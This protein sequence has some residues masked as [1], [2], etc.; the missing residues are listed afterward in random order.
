[1]RSNRKSTAGAR[2]QLACLVFS[3]ARAVHW[4]PST[5]TYDAAILACSRQRQWREALGLMRTMSQTSGPTATAYESV[6][7][8]SDKAGSVPTAAMLLS[9]LGLFMPDHLVLLEEKK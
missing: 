4:P 8:A 7:C 5:L 3:R 6:I 2:W 9:E 1:M